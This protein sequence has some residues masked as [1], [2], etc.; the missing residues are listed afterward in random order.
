MPPTLVAGQWSNRGSTYW[1]QR[2]WRD[3]SN[4]TV[5][6][7]KG[8]AGQQANVLDAWCGAAYRY[9]LDRTYL[10]GPGGD[11][12]GASNESY[13][14]DHV[15]DTSARILDPTPAIIAYAM[16]FTPGGGPALPA[17][18]LR[19]Y[20]RDVNNLYGTPNREYFT[21]EHTYCMQAWQPGT[22][23]IWMCKAGGGGSWA[24]DVYR[25]DQGYHADSPT[26]NGEG[27]PFG[28][29]DTSTNVWTRQASDPG[30][31]NSLGSLVI[32]DEN[33]GRLFVIDYDFFREFVPTRPPSSRWATLAGRS[34]DSTVQHECPCFD[35]KRNRLVAASAGGNI[36]YW[37][38]AAP[39]GNGTV[40][41]AGIGGSPWPGDVPGLD[42]DVARDRYVYWSGGQRVYYINPDTGAVTSD[43]GTGGDTP[44][45][46]GVA[47]SSSHGP[48]NRFRWSQNMDCAV[49][50]VDAWTGSSLFKPTAPL[51]GP[52]YSI[53][54]PMH[55]VTLSDSL[56]NVQ[57]R[58]GRQPVQELDLTQLPGLHASVRRGQVLQQLQRLLTDSVTLTDLLTSLLSSASLTTPQLL[59]SD[60]VQGPRTGNSDDSHASQ[61]AGQDGAYVTLVGTGLVAAT[62]CEVRIGGALARSFYRGP[63]LSPYIQANLY[64]SVQRYEAITVQVNHAA[65]T[66]AQAITVTLDGVLLGST[67]PFQ[68]A[69]GTIRYARNVTGAA[70][71]NTGTWQSPKRNPNAAIAPMVSGDVTYLCVGTDQAAGIDVPEGSRAG[72]PLNPTAPLAVVGYPGD[73]VQLGDITHDGVRINISGGG[74][75]MHY[76]NLQLMGGAPDASPGNLGQA[77]TVVGNCRFTTSR[78][79]VPH[80]VGKSGAIGM[81]GSSCKV[82]G[83]EGTSCGETTIPTDPDATYHV[84][85]IYGERDRGDPGWWEETDREVAYSFF[86]ENCAI[87]CINIFNGMGTDLAGSNPMSNHKIHDNY[88]RSQWASAISFDRGVVG[89]NWAYN[90]VIENCF[91]ADPA[92]G[93]QDCAGFYLRAGWDFGGGRYP[94]AGTVLHIFNNTVRNCGTVGM[95]NYGGSLYWVNALWTPDIHSNLFVQQNG[96]P[97]LAPGSNTP[98]ADAA[99]IRRN[100]WYGQ[101]GVPAWDTNPIAA[102]PR[103][104]STTSTPPD[105]HL[106]TGTPCDDTGEVL[107]AGHLDLDG[108]ARPATTPCTIGA[109]EYAGS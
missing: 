109:Y 98:T 17:G 94:A 89:H 97:Y 76:A 44:G 45:S 11:Q 91:W 62:T 73:T 105:Y 9:D 47:G 82:L 18:N 99:K 53:T 31:F 2:I 66:G 49:V 1:G 85:Y 36:R 51:A 96:S 65:A 108:R 39:S 59:F 56:Q 26:G 80:G 55:T 93:S 83:V 60:L 33:A 52:T 58:I 23:L 77:M 14:I 15:A 75:W 20:Y 101:V 34:N 81:K 61:V 79:Q 13:M 95:G 38:L 21:S 103:L 86:H 25:A 72:G 100:C 8:A 84:V 43:A 107:G 104:T 106:A 12:D 37:N 57:T 48:W 74:Y 10:L 41:V 71:G 30:P 7:L 90:N 69:A 78:I 70:D 40:L 68:I 54:H 3:G 29:F 27:F 5:N 4:N 67:L 28:S 87:R 35:K 6:D 46:V 24:F 19:T 63:A 102:D 16:S 64:N 22:N 50:T 32:W 88:I 92:L 42:M